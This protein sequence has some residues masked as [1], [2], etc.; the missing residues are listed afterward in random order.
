MSRIKDYINWDFDEYLMKLR[1][2]KIQNIS[3]DEGYFDNLVKVNSPIKFNLAG[4]QYNLT[5]DTKEISIGDICVINTESTNYYDPTALAVYL[6]GYKIG[7]VPKEVKELI[8]KKLNKSYEDMNGEFLMITDLP[9]V[10]KINEPCV[11][12]VTVMQ[13]MSEMLKEKL[14]IA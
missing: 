6:R 2:G 7:Y 8:Y 3:R 13:D 12:E 4:V 1:K 14:G 11:I 10:I 9:R 5:N